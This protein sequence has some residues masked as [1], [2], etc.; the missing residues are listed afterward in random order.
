MKFT[1]VV[2]Q[3]QDDGAYPLGLDDIPDAIDFCIIPFF[4][5]VST[6]RRYQ[7]RGLWSECILIPRAC[8]AYKCQNYLGDLVCSLQ[9]TPLEGWDVVGIG[10]F[11]GVLE[12][13]LTLKESMQLSG[14]YV[15]FCRKCQGYS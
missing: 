2:F 13:R 5:D 9:L 7:N 15:P 10:P 14:R 3:F 1:C 4:L 11:L 8:T 12:P 6:V